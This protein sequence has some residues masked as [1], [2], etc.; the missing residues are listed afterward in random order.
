M[1]MAVP[2]EVRNC[3]SCGRDTLNRSQLCRKCGNISRHNAPP[4]FTNPRDPRDDVEG[5]E[6]LIRRADRGDILTDQE[7]DILALTFLAQADDGFAI[8]ALEDDIDSSR[9]DDMVFDYD[10]PTIRPRDY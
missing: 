7:L 9:A 2:E 5:D 4:D 8:L 3:L 1:L 10:Q 6:D